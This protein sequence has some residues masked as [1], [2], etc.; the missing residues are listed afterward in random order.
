MLLLNYRF[1]KKSINKKDVIG[2]FGFNNF[3][4]IFA[5]LVKSIILQ[6]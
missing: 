2:L 6:I 3:E 4:I 1:S 5:L